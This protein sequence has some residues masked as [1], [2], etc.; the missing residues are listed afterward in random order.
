M[1]K[2]RKMLGAA[3]SPYILSLMSLIGHAIFG[4]VLAAVFQA[5]ETAHPS[6]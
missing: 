6:R 4:Y 3:D 1:A 5:F 2:L